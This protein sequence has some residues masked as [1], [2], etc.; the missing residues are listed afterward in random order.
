MMA[1][2]CFHPKPPVTVDS[3]LIMKLLLNL[4]RDRRPV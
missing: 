3:R 1:R 4:K 2:A